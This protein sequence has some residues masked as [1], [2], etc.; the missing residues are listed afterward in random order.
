MYTYVVSRQD[1]LYHHGVKGQKW[2][3]RRYQNEDGTLTKAGIKQK[4]KIAKWYDSTSGKAAMQR[5]KRAGMSKAQ[6]YNAHRTSKAAFIGTLLAGPAVGIISGAVAASRA[7]KGR[8]FTEQVIREFEQ[9]D[10]E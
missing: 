7:D 3:I 2:G 6:A 10:K 9:Q 5:F 4:A 1:E 8:A